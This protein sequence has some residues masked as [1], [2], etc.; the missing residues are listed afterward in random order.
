VGDNSGVTEADISRP[1]L[2]LP[3]LCHFLHLPPAV[4]ECPCAK[5]LY[6]LLKFIYVFGNRY[7]TCFWRQELNI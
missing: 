2:L 7:A 3:A 4:A 1:P 5:E 6:G